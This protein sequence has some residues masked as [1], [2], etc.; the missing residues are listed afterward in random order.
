MALNQAGADLQSCCTIVVRPSDVLI[1]DVFIF[2]RKSLP[3]NFIKS[4][5]FVIIVFSK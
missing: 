3:A 1:T 4:I 5:R 2:P